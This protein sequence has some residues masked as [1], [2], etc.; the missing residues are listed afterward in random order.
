M[1]IKLAA[2]KRHCRCVNNRTCPFAA[3]FTLGRKASGIKGSILKSY[4]IISFHGKLGDTLMFVRCLF[5][6]R[7]NS[8]IKLCACLPW[9]GTRRRTWKIQRLHNALLLMLDFL[10]FFLVLSNPFTFLLFP[11]LFTLPI[12][13]WYPSN[14]PCLLSYLR[15][16]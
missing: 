14:P 10:Y 2:Q 16:S 8:W 12:D 5:S 11:S 9:A 1:L 13:Q 4:Q 15:G 6:V 3:R 7:S